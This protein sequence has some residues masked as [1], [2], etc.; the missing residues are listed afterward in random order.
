MSGGRPHGLV[1]T[2]VRVNMAQRLAWALFKLALYAALLVTVAPIPYY[3]VAVLIHNLYWSPTTIVEAIIIFYSNV[4]LFLFFRRQSAA[5]FGAWLSSTDRDANSRFLGPVAEAGGGQS[6]RMAAWQAAIAVLIASG[7]GLYVVFPSARVYYYALEF[8]R[9]WGVALFFAYLYVV[10]GF[11]VRVARSRTL[12]WWFV[13]WPLFFQFAS[14]T[15]APLSILII[16]NVTLLPLFLLM[17]LLQTVDPRRRVDA[18][19]WFFW[20]YPLIVT[21]AT[22][23]FVI[24]DPA[25]V[26]FAFVQR[27][28]HAYYGVFLFFTAL[29][30]VFVY[31]RRRLQLR[32]LPVSTLLLAWLLVAAASVLATQQ[33]HRFKARALQ[34]G[35]AANDYR[36]PTSPT[37]GPRRVA[38]DPRALNGSGECQRCHPV[39]YR[40]WVASAHAYAVKNKAFQTVVA[41]LIAKHGLDAV[42]D[43]A[44]CHE[45]ALAFSDRLDLLTNPQYLAQS[46]GVSCRACHLMQGSEPRNGIYRVQFPRADLVFSGRDA[47]ARFMMVGV[48]E[49]VSDFT[50]PDIAAGRTCYPCHS[51]E[52]RRNGHS[53]DPLDNVTSFLRSSYAREKHIKCHDC[54]MPRIEK[55]KF[56]YSWRDHRFFGS[57]IYLDEVASET[58]PGARRQLQNFSRSNNDFLFSKL[59]LTPLIPMFMDE[60]LKT[61]KYFNYANGWRKVVTINEVND[62]G[63]AFVAKLEGVSLTDVDGLPTLTFG[64]RLTNKNLGHDFPSSLFANL[65]RVWI[66][67]SLTD[68]QDR[69][70]RQRGCREDEFPDQLGRLEV[71]KKGR[72]ISPDETKDYVRIVNQKYIQPDTGYF[73][74]RCAPLPPDVHWPLRLSYRLKYQR[75][76]DEQWR[77]MTGGQGAEAPVLPLL[78]WETFVAKPAARP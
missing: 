49:H 22:G 21:L 77:A 15:P 2:L 4:R 36:S 67:C 57:Q 50:K 48:L 9:A 61:Y 38:L 44:V 32:A 12:A 26:R 71:D 3:F 70:L 66:E 78:Q 18:L 6:R 1:P 13:L 63:V 58:D 16:Y 56:S 40:Q 11:I 51:L 28:W 73:D 39:A 62:S 14:R 43:C 5:S 59:A 52:A 42:R 68:A 7:V 72:P 45:P 8:H 17:R 53:Y 19:L 27:F 47:R 65:V 76:N 34:T 75:Y 46:E 23:L 41:S 35:Y 25:N 33:M 64:V 20:S 31:C 74:Q 37:A 54:H 60:T 10:H 69:V 29:F 30:N 55:D 24:S